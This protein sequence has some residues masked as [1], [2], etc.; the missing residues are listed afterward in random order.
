MVTSR[1]TDCLSF[2]RSLTFSNLYLVSDFSSSLWYEDVY[3]RQ[4]QMLV[5]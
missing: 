3:K 2:A 5:L 1:E 4:V